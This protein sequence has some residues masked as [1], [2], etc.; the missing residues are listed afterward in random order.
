MPTDPT[1]PFAA[2]PRKRDPNSQS[3]DDF[4]EP[5]VEYDPVIRSV[6]V[7]G[8]LALGFAAV[9]TLLLVY[10]SYIWLSTDYFTWDQANEFD[11]LRAAVRPVQIGLYICLCLW[12][13]AVANNLREQRY[14]APKTGWIWGGWWIPFANIVIPAKV[15]FELNTRK[16][17]SGLWVLLW[18]A[19]VLTIWF[20]EFTERGNDSAWTNKEDYN[21]VMWMY[22]IGSIV[23][24]ISMTIVIRGIS[25]GHVKGKFGTT[26]AEFE[27]S[28]EAL[29]RLKRNH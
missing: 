16:T 22:I 12:M 19:G 29:E 23:A 4:P 14:D 5:S 6:T 11:S 18:W 24:M 21:T 8:Y 25:A 9:V 1:D 15:M 3:L 28:E 17:I 7:Q 13:M 10:T 2:A 20:G 27:T 26:E